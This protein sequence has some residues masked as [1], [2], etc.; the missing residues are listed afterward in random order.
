MAGKR[1]GVLQFASRLRGA[2]ER[3]FAEALQRLKAAGAIVVELDFEPPDDLSKS[4]FAV[5]LTELKSGLNAY[6]AT[7]PAAVKARTL[8]DV[9]AFNRTTPRET[10]L[11]GQ[12]LLEKAEATAGLD[13]PAYLKAR[14]DSL[15]AAGAEGIDRLLGGRQLDALIAPTY[16][17]AGRID[18]SGDHHLGGGSTILPAIAGY[19][20]LTVPMGQ[21]LGLP[22][23]LS[24]IGPAWSDAAMLA[25]GFAFERAA[26]ARRPP[27]YLPTLE[28][29][30]DF[31]A[32]CAPALTPAAPSRTIATNT[33]VQESSDGR[34]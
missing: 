23:G 4:E 21:A 10:A 2:A 1:L 22:L 31:A 17:P 26:Q 32:A 24:F 25:L 7:M 34:R 16:G 29:S 14:A 30:A 15:R 11:F 20:H 18:L 13:D 8:A 3:V 19:P 9:I 6:F 28:D 27:T 33:N 12:D 5:L